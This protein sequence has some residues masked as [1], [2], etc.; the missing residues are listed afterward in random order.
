MVV[1][2]DVSVF[3]DVGLVVAPDVSV[4]EDLGMVVAPDVSVWEG[5]GMVVAPDVTAVTVL[6]ASMARAW[7]SAWVSLAVGLTEKTIPVPQ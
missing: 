1:A 7:N 5:V 3:E 4:F 2:T 6:L